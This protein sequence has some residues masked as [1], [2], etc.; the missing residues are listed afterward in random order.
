VSE[1]TRLCIVTP[2][3]PRATLGG[4]ELQIDYLLDG[5]ISSGRFE[6]TY[7]ARSV[8]AGFRPDGYRIMRL[9]HRNRAPRFGYA[10]DA[11]QLYSAL[12]RLRPHVI[13]QRVACGYSAVC[14]FYARRH[15]ARLI[16]HVAHDNDLVAGPL[17]TGRNFIRHAIESASIAYTIRHADYIVTQT[18]RQSRILQERHRRRADAQVP[19]FHPEPVERIDKDGERTVLWVANFKRWKQPEV[20]VELAARLADLPGVRFRMVGDPNVGSGDRHWCDQ[21]LRRIREV[22]N[23]EF[24]GALSPA[25]VNAQLARAHL[26]V[27]TSVAE[28]FPNT[29]IQAWMRETPVVSLNVDPDQVL[30]RERIGILAASPDNLVAAVRGLMTNDELRSAYAA[31]ARSYALRTHSLRNIRQLIDLIESARASTA[32]P[33]NAAGLPFVPSPEPQSRE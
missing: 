33:R 22:P 6:I 17:D 16:W 21:V 4:A 3:H 24:V 28:G 5:L 23:L 20:F 7:L 15:G 14:A 2:H 8:D 18:A 12:R 26:F 10:M 32:A 25:E 1:A 29:F 31:R 30:E 27:N 9:G 19:N 13:Y 11:P